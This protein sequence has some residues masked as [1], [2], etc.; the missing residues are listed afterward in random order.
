MYETSVLIVG[1]GPT[2]LT[3]AL[4]LARRG[5]RLRLIEAAARAFEGSRGKGIQ[6]RTLEI[7]EDLGVID[8]LL[9]AGAP[10]PKFRTHIGGFSLRAGSIGSS[11]P[12]TQGVPYPNLWM[13]PQSRT[14]AILRE[15]L[16]V[17]GGEVEFGKALATFT[18]SEEG[19]LATLAS[20]ETVRADFLVGCDGG[21][22]SVRKAL[23]LRLVGELLDDKPM[24]VADV[25]I[26]GLDR[27]DWHLWPFAT[28]G[29]IG[30][31]PLPG[32]SLFQFMSQASTVA[33]GLE[34]VVHKVTGHRVRRI[35][36]SSTYQPAVRMAERY[37]V[38][39]VFLA[40]DAA[41]VH[42]PSGGQ[43]LN[44]GVQDAHN[45]GWKLAHAVRGGPQGL[46]DTY[47]AERLP[48]AAAVLGLSKRLYQ[49]RSIRRGVATNQLGLHYRTSPLSSG[50]TLGTLHPGDRMPDAR[51]A[52]GSRLFDQLRG[53]H[54]TELITS[55]GP[56]ILIRP[57]GYI[58]H[59]SATHC[60][61]YAGE[62]TH[63]TC[64][65]VSQF[66]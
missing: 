14:E 5:I 17:L 38:G 54:A 32:T 66:I 46:L 7:F 29:M 56:R 16:R 50:L 26:E 37:R 24:V 57:D 60:G 6:P 23:G 10:Y 20:G 19:V 3:L 9:A 52:D 8:A 28:G 63:L 47:E 35:A 2:G 22:S 65:S 15:R 42:P 58:A 59:I 53:P 11:R 51:L 1:A 64:A 12:P 39:R 13:V 18:H 55:E 30:L 27:R 36:W 4:D 62:P 44:T 21:R 43:G 25:E 45:L 40:G 31:C 61:E 41:H 34:H 48:I 33:A 49:T